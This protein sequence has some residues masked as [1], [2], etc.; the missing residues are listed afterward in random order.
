MPSACPPA[1][2]LSAA[3]FSLLLA[4]LLIAASPLTPAASAQGVTAGAATESGS[5]SDTASKADT[6]DAVIAP[7]LDVLKDEAARDRLIQALETARPG[8]GEAAAAEE[9]AP[10]TLAAQL[11]TFTKGA[12][13]EALDIGGRFL[14]D[15][16]GAT[17]LFD[18]RTQIDWDRIGGLLAPL[19]LTIA[20]SLGIY[21]AAKRLARGALGGIERRLRDRGLIAA[22]TLIALFFLAEI[23]ALAIAYF[24]TGA[25]AATLF[26]PGGVSFQQ[27]LYLNAF[28]VTGITAIVIRVITGIVGGDYALMRFAPPVRAMIRSRGIRLSAILIFGIAFVVPAANSLISFT[29]GRSLRVVVYSLAAIYAVRAIHALSRLQ[30][31]AAR[32]P[33]S[34]PVEEA[35]AAVEEA[36]PEPVQSAIMQVWPLIAY[37]YIGVSYVIAL[38][39]PALF[40]DFVG[41]ATLRTLAALIVGAL[42]LRATG[43]LST[44]RVRTPGFLPLD[45][46]A[47]STRLTSFVPVL[48]RVVWLLVTI[49]ILAVVIDSWA[50]VDV[51]AWL[52]GERGSAIVAGLISALIVVTVCAIVWAAASSWIDYRMDHS[53]G[54]ARNAAR[55]R[56]LYSLLKNALTVALVVFGGMIA[57]SELGIDIGPLLAGA[58]VLGLAIGFGAQKLVQDI[59]SGI[60]IQLENAMNV[61]DVVGAGGI[62]GAVERLTLRSV[63]LRDLSGTYHIIPFSSVDSVSNYMRNFS[64][65]VEQVGIAYKENV[66]DGK[67]A[68]QEAFDRLMQTEHKSDILGPL[69]MHGVTGLGDSAVMIRARI[70]T[71]PGQQWGLGRAYTELVKQVMDE[72][73]IEIPF[74]HTTLFLGRDKEGR[75]DELP[76]KLEQVGAKAEGEADKNGA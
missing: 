23:A 21:F 53:T 42:V 73:G 67:A 36:L 30:Q 56:T 59:I 40:V 41:G 71:K 20:I 34:E 57:L 22:I 50:L 16:S 4:A 2:R 29:V 62:T 61:G 8:A 64:Y 26:G 44:L 65:H 31:E 43:Y 63:S 68:M 46:Q 28:L 74:P 5:A 69:E 38:S 45:S 70:K 3:L 54:S 47:L 49:A 9:E 72:K 11:A 13:D 76:V 39:R 15:L 48:M 58:G 17:S 24:A 7:L 35:D 18:G 6:T 27:T 55:Y 51:G 33:A 10:T 14:S 1:R 60:F 12:I 25:L 66:A 19:A 37:V 52:E 75:T 32:R